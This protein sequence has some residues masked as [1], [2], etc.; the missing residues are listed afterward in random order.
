MR[1][2]WAFLLVWCFAAPVQSRPVHLT[3][4]VSSGSHHLLTAGREAP[5]ILGVW[6]HRLRAQDPGIWLEIQSSGELA[7]LQLPQPP[8]ILVPGLELLNA[9]RGPDLPDTAPW[10]LLNLG[11]LP[12]YPPD[13]PLPPPERLWQH[14]DGPTLRFVGL[15]PA[16]TPKEV[17]PA[18]LRPWHIHDP[19][20][21]LLAQLPRWRREPERLTVVVLPEGETAADWSRAFPEIPLWIEPAQGAP[22]VIPLEDGRLRVRPAAHGRAVIRVSLVWDTVTRRFSPPQAEI[23]W[24]QVPDFS[25]HPLPRDLS[26]RVRLLRSA[27]DPAALLSQLQARLREASAADA[28]LLP[29]VRPQPP[30][31]P[32]VPDAWRVQFF[33]RDDGMQLVHLSPEAARELSRLSLPGYHWVGNR[34]GAASFLLPNRIA[35]GARFPEVRRILDADLTTA[36]PLSGTLRQWLF[37]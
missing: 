11:I 30:A 10:T 9:T 2:G 17:P 37:P 13:T 36:T 34:T 21:R 35:A 27:P 3:L 1:G 33:P 23:E 19:H 16:Q 29:E 24:V 6:Q 28:L 5:G 15:L 12:Q 18:L 25:A 32:Y 14:P 4:W 31:L 8:D 26:A 7:A 20:A 22:A